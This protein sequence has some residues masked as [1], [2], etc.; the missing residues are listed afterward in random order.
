MSEDFWENRWIDKNIGWDLGM[1]SPPIKEYINQITDK[2][3]KILI[4]G[5]GNAYEAEY[6]INNGFTNVYIVEISISAIRSFRMRCPFFKE[7]NI[8][9]SNFF[10]ISGQ[11]D[12]IL[13]QTF[14]CAL[15]PS[16][17]ENY[18]E[19]MTKLLKSDGKLIGL[20]FNT[21]FSAGPPFGGDVNLY[22]SLFSESFKIEIMEPAYNSVKPREGSELFIKMIK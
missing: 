20:L 9:H 21:Y 2:S 17:R 10:D 13:E 22:E 18:V 16:F 14:F 6:L 5:C 7:E 19:Q 12:L 3:I 11:F 8:I 4:P 1:V 15:E